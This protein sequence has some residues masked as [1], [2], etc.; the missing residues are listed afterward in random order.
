MALN[1][2][3]LRLNADAHAG[4]AF[5]CKVELELDEDEGVGTYI[6]YDDS[7]NELARRD[8]TDAGQYLNRQMISLR[9]DDG[10]CL[11]EAF[12]DV[13]ARLLWCG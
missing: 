12:G 8:V 2:E 13:L 5:D 3:E 1:F 10:E 6:L 4:N 9:E 11:V 7:G